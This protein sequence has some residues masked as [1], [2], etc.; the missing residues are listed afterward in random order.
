M[1]KFSVLSLQFLHFVLPWS[2]QS[3]EKGKQS[4]AAFIAPLG[5][6]LLARPI[7]RQ[8]ICFQSCCPKEQAKLNSQWP[9][10]VESCNNVRTLYTYYTFTMLMFTFQ[11]TSF[12]KSLFMH[13]SFQS[14]SSNT[15]SRKKDYVFCKHDNVKRIYRSN[16][17]VDIIF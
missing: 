8:Y 1:T 13:E 17:N 2:R 15:K 16:K 14:G 3:I 7:Y 12:H 6:S 9:W 10:F 5:P 4:A 11:N